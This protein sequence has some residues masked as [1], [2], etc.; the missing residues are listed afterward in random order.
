MKKKNPQKTPPSSRQNPSAEL[1]WHPRTHPFNFFIK[2]CVAQWPLSKKESHLAHDSWSPSALLFIQAGSHPVAGCVH[3]LYKVNQR[4]QLN[5]GLINNRAATACLARAAAAPPSTCDTTASDL[6]EW[7][8]SHR[9]FRRL[10]GLQQHLPHKQ[11]D[12]RLSYEG[13][14]HSVS[15]LVCLYELVLGESVSRAKART[16]FLLS[17]MRVIY[18]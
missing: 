10:Q 13:Q 6:S 18:A 7:T 12:K 16:G 8:F 2:A 5:E 14:S 4:W 1:L 3:I 17:F 11:S 9:I 15:R